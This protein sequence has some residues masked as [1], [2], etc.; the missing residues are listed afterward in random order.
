MTIVNLSLDGYDFKQIAETV[1]TFRVAGHGL[2][3]I[4][5]LISFF[6]IYKPDQIAPQCTGYG[7]SPS[8]LPRFI[9]IL[10]AG[11]YASGLIGLPWDFLVLWAKK[12]LPDNSSILTDTYFQVSVFGFLA[13]NIWLILIA[14][15]VVEVIILLQIIDRNM[16]F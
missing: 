9:F 1:S 7:D 13:L 10:F 8:C 11:I 12:S 14:D 4:G 3:L 6:T 16:L 2:G 5:I 15:I